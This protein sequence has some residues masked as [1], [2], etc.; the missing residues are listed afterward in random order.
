[1][2]SL[3]KKG[4][5]SSIKKQKKIKVA[6][7]AHKVVKRDFLSGKLVFYCLFDGQSSHDHISLCFPTP[8][9]RTVHA[10]A[11]PAGEAP[12]VAKRIAIPVVA[13]MVSVKMAHVFVWPDGM[14]FIVPLRDVPMGAPIMAAVKLISEENG[15]AIVILDGRVLIVAFDWRLVATMD[16][17]MTKVS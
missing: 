12:D 5:K 14:G 1:M 13:F 9:V 10:F 4:Q 16:M 6:R 11:R 2:T 3:L 7:F 8:D 17:T 15:A